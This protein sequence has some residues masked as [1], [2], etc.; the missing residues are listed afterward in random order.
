MQTWNNREDGKCHVRF[1]AIVGCRS[2]SSKMMENDSFSLRFYG[3]WFMWR[4][5]VIHLWSGSLGGGA[6]QYGP[7]QP[8]RVGPRGF[9]K[10]VLSMRLKMAERQR[11]SESSDSCSATNQSVFPISFH[12]FGPE[13]TVVVE[14]TN[15]SFQSPSISLDFKW[16]FSRTNQS[17]FPIS[18]H[19]FGLQVTV[20][21]ELTN[22]SFHPFGR[23]NGTSKE[24]CR[25]CQQ[26]TLRSRVVLHC[27]SS[28]S[29]SSF[30]YFL[31]IPVY[32]HTHFLWRSG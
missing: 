17:V 8:P 31:L 26:A 27:S 29:S 30:I 32:W 2:V 13:M 21:V 28:S 24:L 23:Q 11:M 14:L 6:H 1:V 5:W 15:R 10:Q 18:F 4:E 12:P 7:W 25:Q 22:R 3:M 16:P 9:L 19:P 20:V